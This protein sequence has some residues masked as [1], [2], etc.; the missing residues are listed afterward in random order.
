MGSLTNCLKLVGLHKIES[1]SIISAAGA[2]RKKGL[3]V[4]ESTTG[5]VRDAINA[6]ETER[7]SIV[8]QIRKQLPEYFEADIDVKAQE[9]ATSPTSEAPMP[10]DAQIKAGTYK[11]GHVKKKVKEPWEMTRDEF[12]GETGERYF[13]EKQYPGEKGDLFLRFTKQ[14]F[15]DIENKKSRW[16]EPGIDEETAKIE[17]YLYDKNIGEYY[18]EHSGLSG[19]ELD[20]L[21][22]PEAIKEI[23]KGG[24]WRDIDS[25][26]YAIYEDT[27]RIVAQDTPEGNTFEPYKVLFQSKKDINSF[28][29]GN[30]AEDHKIFIKQALSE[31]KPVPESVLKDYPELKVKPKKTF[32]KPKQLKKPLPDYT[33][34][35]QLQESLLEGKMILK[36]GRT[37]TGRKM[38]ESELDGVRRSIKSAQEKLSDLTGK[39]VFDLDKI[40][41]GWSVAVDPEFSKDV[42]WKA[43]VDWRTMR[44]VFETVDDLN[45]RE[46][47][48]HELAHLIVEDKLIKI[49]PFSMQSMSEAKSELLRNYAKLTNE[50]DVHPNFVREHLTMDYSNY[51]LN[52]SSVTPAKIELFRKHLP[53]ATN[54]GIP[55]VAPE[56]KTLKKK[57]KKLEKGLKT[58][59]KKKVEISPQKT[60]KKQEQIST[61]DKKSFIP[62]ESKPKTLKKTERKTISFYDK[63]Q[64]E[65]TGLFVREIT[66]GKKK[67]Y[68]VV[69]YQG[70]NLT[71]EPG[72]IKSTGT[73]F[74]DAGGYS[75]AR[76]SF[77][78]MPE[79][80]EL[81][82]SLL[83]GEVPKIVKKI[84]A[85]SGRALGQVSLRTGIKAD[86]KLVADLFK[87]TGAALKTLAHEIGH[88]VDLLPEKLLTRGNILGRIASLKKYGKHFLAP[89]PR[90]KGPLSK[91]DKSRLMKEARR[92][93]DK[94]IEQI[95]D[96]EIRKE[97]PVSPDDILNI[98]RQ[99]DASIADP[100]LND[101]IARLSA[102]EKK[103]IVKD[104]LKGKVADWVS[105]KRVKVTHEK[106]TVTLKGKAREK[107]IVKKYHDLIQEETKKRML[108]ERDIIM[109]ELKELTQIWKPFTAIK[110]DKFTNY[111]HSSPEL[112]ADAVSVLLNN[113][114][115]LKTVAPNFYRGFFAYMENKPAMKEMYTLIQDRIKSSDSDIK[116]HRQKRARG[117]F[118]REKDII[119]EQPEEPSALD[120]FKEL[121]S[122]LYHGLV[123]KDQGIIK[124]GKTAAKKAKKEGRDIPPDDIRYWTEELPYVSSQVFQLLRDVDNLVEKVASEGNLT[125]EDLGEIMFERRVVEERNEMANPLGFD[126]K[127]A[128]EQMGYLKE[129]LGSEKWSV[130]TKAVNNFWEIRKTK[131][132]PVLKEANM[133]SP[134]LMKYIEENPFYVTFNV[135]GHLEENI[136]KN[137]GPK[138]YHQIGTFSDIGN[139]FTATVIKDSS[140]I[141]AAQKKIVAKKVVTWMQKE[142]STEIKPASYKMSKT[143]EGHAY[144]DYTEPRKGSGVG[145]ITFM[146]GGKL[147]AYYVPENVAETFNRDPYEAG[148]VH[149]FIQTIQKPFRALF[150]GKNPF[151]A[152]WNTQRDIRG[153]AT[154]LPGATILK[155]LKH[156]AKAM[157]HAYKDVFK[158]YS[159]DLVREMYENKLLL[160]GRTYTAKNV[161]DP[162]SDFDRMMQS[163][164]LSQ[165]QYSNAVMAEFGKL[166]ESLETPGKFSERLIKI[167]GYSYLKETGEGGDTK[168][169]GHLVR[170][171]AGSPDFYRRG[172]WYRLYNNLF[173]FSNAGKEGWRSSI[174]AA[175]ESPLSFLWKTAKYDLI[176]KFM[177]YGASI[178]LLT[179]IGRR[180]DDEDMER[181]GSWLEQAY[182]KIPEHDKTNYLCIPFDETPDG[183]TVYF[184]MPHDFSS[185]V[186]AGLFWKLLKRDDTN[187]IN[188][189]FD[190]VAGGLPYQSLSPPLSMGLDIYQYM[191]GKNPYDTYR[192][193]V[194][195]NQTKFDAGGSIKRKEFVKQTWNRYGGRYFYTFPYDDLDKVK[196]NLEKNIKMPGAS[197]FFN[198]FVRISKRGISEELRAAGKKATQKK[199]IK[200]EQINNRIIE[201]LNKRTGHPKGN[202]RELF[203]QL[204]SEGYPIKSFNVFYNK[205]VKY[206]AKQYNRTL[207]N[208][209]NQA[210]S[211]EAK[212][213]ILEKYYG[214]EIPAR[215]VPILVRGMKKKQK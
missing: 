64:K 117:M 74:A 177:M 71:I 188:S 136:G 31:N 174:E 45:N 89:Y 63:D 49:E 147:E 9:A 79:M 21:T 206:R 96:V 129:Q 191:S 11:K 140:L 52:P 133:F 183:K 58:I 46:I 26:S 126:A 102:A 211:N 88:V 196:S 43:Q 61:E 38:T 114:P 13:V 42:G 176:P 141:K 137:N 16:Y 55:K 66:K 125:R 27:G 72:K 154:K 139:P 162:Q 75:P 178:G 122:D 149:N 99:V 144:K 103:S 5:A 148:M 153:A 23:K 29:S 100:M 47:R 90:A 150:V 165:K 209:L 62:K 15:K 172:G 207:F 83:G 128:L 7:N 40:V 101:F 87:D 108:L 123:D 199:A 185:Q 50:L 20:A 189:I 22:L 160:I 80:V 121:F 175:K 203:V 157:P 145:M 208:A 179:A 192:G 198:R 173:M 4:K 118:E 142:F 77:M 187:N 39:D 93:L 138:I 181:Q 168:R 48:I 69:N 158:S 73:T 200:T 143:I 60:L 97:T 17:G 159:T 56:K 81:A 18:K 164:S 152:I 127:A 12:V 98:W 82:Q 212:K 170:T 171:R 68:T 166:W 8:S 163:F 120:E 36:S 182:R 85:F 95:I 25:D 155:I 59:E 30:P 132:T 135:L 197:Q 202:A 94:N 28:A 6:T 146:E 24:Y 76:P 201:M 53:D 186:I 112:Y 115:L 213:A 116:E 41:K 167:A 205:V 210:P 3:G 105:F 2:Y 70:R 180:L 91:Q 113:P 161:T 124:K 10:T 35:N 67:G 151:W 37:A 54:I 78:E 106:K 51:L 130:L 184:V 169:T 14:P 156:T 57:E 134:E 107:E 33:R 131:V 92:L 215:L 32:K 1:G 109:S 111:R 190:F 195:I 204:R 86:M 65:R 19:H 194:M 119:A 104:A 193:R 84:R 44:L 214:Q 34:I 110:G